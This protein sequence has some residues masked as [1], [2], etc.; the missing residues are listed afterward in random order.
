MSDF[1]DLKVS[2]AELHHTPFSNTGCGA[3]LNLKYNSLIDYVIV[4]F[5]FPFNALTPAWARILYIL[6]VDPKVF[7]YDDVYR[8]GY[9]KG[10]WYD[11]NILIMTGGT[12]NRSDGLET[13][14][15]QMKGEACRDYERREGYSWKELLG[16]LLDNSIDKIDDDPQGRFDVDID[17]YSGRITAGQI[18]NKV[19]RHDYTTNTRRLKVIKSGGEVIDPQWTDYQNGGWS[20][21]F[22]GTQS[23]QLCIYD[24][25][26]ERRHED[27]VV[28]VDS[29]IRYEARFFRKNAYEAMRAVYA[30]LCVQD[31][32]PTIVSQVVCGLV[33]GILEFKAKNDYDRADRYKAPIW[34]RWAELLQNAAKIK[35][36]NQA[37]IELSIAK[38]CRHVDNAYGKCLRKTELLNQHDQPVYE[39]WVKYHGGMRITNREIAMINYSRGQANLPPIDRQSIINDTKFKY[40]W[41]VEAPADIPVDRFYL[42]AKGRRVTSEGEVIR[43]SKKK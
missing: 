39:A 33:G 19:N 42:D 2:A 12:Q 37:N 36:A 29:W 43:K 25:S 10:Y 22:G 3:D 34:D 30:A 18:K 41:S 21:T 23:K 26:A 5:P 16:A 38:L 17:D 32:N 4:Q 27:R 6:C 40:E 14:V 11:A 28:Y 8:R 20:A 9:T 31:D 24:K 35:I 7:D 1:K 13:S 15:L